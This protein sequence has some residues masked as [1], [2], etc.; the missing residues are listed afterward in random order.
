MRQRQG[1]YVEL[2]RILRGAERALLDTE[3]S[4]AAPLACW[5]VLIPRPLPQ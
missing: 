3:Y 1:L 4:I 5:D 2:Q